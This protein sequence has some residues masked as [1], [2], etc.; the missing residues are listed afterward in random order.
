MGVLNLSKQ[1]ITESR[2]GGM[3]VW[4]WNR[5]Q[6][7]VWLIF[8][9]GARLPKCLGLSMQMKMGEESDEGVW[10]GQGRKGGGQRRGWR[11][12][13]FKTKGN[14]KG[15]SGKRGGIEL[16]QYKVASQRRLYQGTTDD[17]IKF[18]IRLQINNK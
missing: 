8:H 1:I 16:V 7:L 14:R 2:E 10:C 5:P 6:A 4:L 9:G 11:K 3:A 13:G 15:G 17:N 18:F 12:C